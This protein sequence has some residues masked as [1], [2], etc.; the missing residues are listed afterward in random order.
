MCAKRVYMS[1]NVP[2]DG[3]SSRHRLEFLD[4]GSFKINTKSKLFLF[5]WR[6]S[7]IVTWLVALWPLDVSQTVGSQFDPDFQRDLLYSRWNIKGSMDKDLNKTSA[8]TW[9][10]SCIVSRSLITLWYAK[11]QWYLID[12]FI[13]EPWRWTD[14]CQ[15]ISL[16]D[17]YFTHFHKST[18]SITTIKGS[19]FQK[20]MAKFSNLSNRHACEPKIVPELLFPV[21]VVDII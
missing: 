12:S 21:S 4:L 7:K 8:G 10:R 6:V 17:P 2:C 20:V 13:Y 15:T 16:T 11:R 18:K 1:H 19:F 9:A 14:C 3:A 5:V